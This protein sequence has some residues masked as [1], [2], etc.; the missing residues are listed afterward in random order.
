MLTTLANPIL[1]IF[2][3][4][5]LGYVLHRSGLFDVPV[6]QAINKFVF[7]CAAN[8]RADL[9]HNGSTTH[10]GYRISGCGILVLRHG[11]GSG[12]N[13]SQESF[14]FEGCR[15]ADKKSVSDYCNIW[16]RGLGSG[17][18]DT[19]RCVYLCYVCRWCGGAGGTFCTPRTISA[20][21]VIF[22]RSRRGIAVAL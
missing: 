3:I 15:A 1:P 4:L 18:G 16:G 5:A 13:A 19:A 21:R 6:A 7:L 10:R 14:S 12:C 11:A 20:N 22:M 2:A 8:C 9:R 17:S